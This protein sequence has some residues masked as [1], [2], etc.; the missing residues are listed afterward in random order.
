MAAAHAICGYVR[1]AGLAP[2]LVA[3][4]RGVGGATPVSQS[5]M[6]GVDADEESDNNKSDDDRHDLGVIAYF[7]SEHLRDGNGYL[8]EHK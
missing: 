5:A 7:P 6:G 8:D 1:M 3:V 2:F 4:P